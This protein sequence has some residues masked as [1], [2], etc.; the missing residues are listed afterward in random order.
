MSGD[1][2]LEPGAAWI[3]S[4]GQVFHSRPGIIEISCRF[5]GLVNFPYD[6]LSCPFEMIVWDYGDNVVNLTFFD[7]GGVVVDGLNSDETA[8]EATVTSY[9]EYKIV[10]VE[11]SRVPQRFPC[12]TY[13]F[14]TLDF[15]L[16]FTR[17]NMYY[18]WAVEVPGV[19]LTVVSMAVFWLDATNCGERLGFGVTALLAVE[20]RMI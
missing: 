4:S 20:V 17:P 15:R 2:T 12:C 8:V 3:Y 9:Q 18:F 1:D 13:T 5:G 10:S 16:H 19:L 6:E 7:A 14:T 11:T